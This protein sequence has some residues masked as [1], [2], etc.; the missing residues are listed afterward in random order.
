MDR[1]AQD[2][3]YDFRTTAA[4]ASPATHREHEPAPSRPEQE[5]R[6]FGEAPL[7]WPVCFA[8]SGF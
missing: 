6:A 1:H 8:G 7:A 2:P 3:D 5:S 4:Q